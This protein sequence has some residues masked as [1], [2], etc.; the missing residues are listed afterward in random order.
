MV[1]MLFEVKQL[2]ELFPSGILWEK[3]YSCYMDKYS[4][5]IIALE[6]IVIDQNT[7]LYPHQ[8]TQSY[9]YIFTLVIP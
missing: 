1:K 2:K 4:L 8:Y 6:K 5:P 3:E 7:H 9:I